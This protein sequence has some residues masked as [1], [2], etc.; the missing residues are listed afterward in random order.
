MGEVFQREPVELE[1]R[2][3]FTATFERDVLR[4]FVVCGQCGERLRKRSDYELDHEISLKI[5]GK[6]AVENVRPLC[7]DCHK[8]KTALDAKILGKAKRLAGETCA[9]QTRRP[10]PKRTDGGWPP[11]GSRKIPSR[12]KQERP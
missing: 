9:G 1:N 5:G 10:I 8:R 3:A 2:Q 11:R 4:R 6:H 7:I 12:P